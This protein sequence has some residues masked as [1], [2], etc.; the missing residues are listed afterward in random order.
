MGNRRMGARRINAL[1]GSNLAE[2]N[3]NSAGAGIKDAIESSTV[4]RQGSQITTEIVIDLASSKGT[5][6]S[7]GAVNQV[8]GV[9]SSSGTHA[10]AYLTQL[11]TAINGIVTDAEIICTETPTTGEPDINLVYNASSTLGFGD[12]G[13][14]DTLVD[15]GAD[16]VIGYNKVGAGVN[17]NAAANDYVYLTAGVGTPD[18]DE[19]DTGKLI[20]RIYG[21][22]VGSDL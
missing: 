3:R 14:T 11:T 18:N 13:G 7:P 2:D 5:L 20:I 10:D 1:L 15:T 12:A 4:H 21:Y 8:I 17:D 6:K 19:Y 9:S 16:F 22:A